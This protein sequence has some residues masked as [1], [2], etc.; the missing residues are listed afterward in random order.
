MVRQQPLSDARRLALRFLVDRE[1]IGVDRFV[2]MNASLQMPARK[3]TAVS[4]G[5]SARPKTSDRCAL[6]ITVID[7][8]GEIGLARAGVCER[9]AD[10]SFPGD[11]WNCVSGPQVGEGA[12]GKQQKERT[13]GKVKFHR[14]LRQGQKVRLSAKSIL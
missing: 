1:L 9:F 4:A 8:T 14:G 11:G 5:K 10:A 7:K 2:F 12:A 3:V 6:P 13:L